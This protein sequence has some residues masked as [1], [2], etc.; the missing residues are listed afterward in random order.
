MAVL[1]RLGGAQTGGSVESRAAIAELREKVEK[2]ISTGTAA[3][4]TSTPGNIYIRSGGT[5]GIYAKIDGTWTQVG[6]VS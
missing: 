1:R 2:D 3:P 5:P 6:N 4:D